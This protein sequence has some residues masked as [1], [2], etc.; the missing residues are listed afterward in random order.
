MS[1]ARCQVL[2]PPGA[3]RRSAIHMFGLSK[4]HSAAVC[5]P[6]I[7]RPAPTSPHLCWPVRALY[8]NLAPMGNS[9][10]T[11]VLDGLLDPLSRC[12]DAESARRITEFHIAPEVQARVDVLAE[13]AN[14]GAL[15]EE[16]KTEYEAFINAADFI[17]VLKLKAKRQLTASAS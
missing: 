4:S 10:D 7:I 11:A 15:T 12:L 9:I 8:A 16:E 3:D 5:Q 1:G 17:S 2:G 13:Q 6:G 14:D